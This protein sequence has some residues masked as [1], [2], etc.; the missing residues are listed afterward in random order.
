LLLLLSVRKDKE[1]IMN[2]SLRRRTEN[3]TEVHKPQLEKE[4]LPELLH[5]LDQG[6][7]RYRYLQKTGAPDVLRDVEISLFRNRL[8]ALRMELKK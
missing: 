8:L 7:K 2:L 5:L 4:S 1:E 3:M 6:L